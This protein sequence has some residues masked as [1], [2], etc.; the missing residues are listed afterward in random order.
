MAEEAVRLTERLRD[1]LDLYSLD[2]RKTMT[3]RRRKQEK[4]DLQRRGLPPG[5]PRHG[6]LHGYTSFGCRCEDCTTAR[7]EY[8]RGRAATI[9]VHAEGDG[10]LRATRPWPPVRTER[11]AGVRAGSI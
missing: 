8:E 9:A 4:K 2:H 3:R 10:D 11:N 1:L 7:R 6:T 5:D